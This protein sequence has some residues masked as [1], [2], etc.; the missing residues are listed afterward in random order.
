[1]SSFRIDDVEDRRDMG[2][3]VNRLE[4]DGSMGWGGGGASAPEGWTGAVKEAPEEEEEVG[5]PPWSN[6]SNSNR[7]LTSMAGSGRGGEHWAIGDQARADTIK[8]N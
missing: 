6:C 2:L 4:G 3:D 8:Q 5:E 1:M 7:G